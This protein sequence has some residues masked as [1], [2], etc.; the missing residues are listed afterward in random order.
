MD[1][2]INVASTM[3][4][5]GTGRN[6][7]N[8]FWRHDTKI[9]GSC[10]MENGNDMDTFLTTLDAAKILQVS[11][12]TI[13]VWERRGKLPAIRT[14]GGMRLFRREDVELLATQRQTTEMTHD[15]VSTK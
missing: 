3:F 2:L 5:P 7:A 8:L 12:D 6:Y 14:Q 13:R 15:E 10:I 11:P 9:N 4:C 1:S